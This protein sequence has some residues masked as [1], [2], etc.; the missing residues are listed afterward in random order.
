MF[1]L[2]KSLEIN[3]RLSGTYRSIYTP[4]EVKTMVLNLTS[5]AKSLKNFFD[6]KSSLNFLTTRIEGKLYIET[7]ALDTKIY[8]HI[9]RN[10]K[11]GTIDYYVNFQDN[12]GDFFYIKAEK[13]ISL[14]GFT[15]SF[16]TLKGSVYKKLTHEKIADI[17]LASEYKNL[18]DII[19]SVKLK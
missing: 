7:I 8:G 19:K 15:N 3:E 11:N 14:I 12:N 6:I 17:H 9:L 10:I 2:D 16:L 18:K 1:L 13:T 4:G 5:K